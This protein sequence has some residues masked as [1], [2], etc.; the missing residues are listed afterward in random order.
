MNQKG[1]HRLHGE[2]VAP[3]IKSYRF[4]SDTVL[5]AII[6]H[7]IDQPFGAY[8]AALGWSS[9]LFH[10]SRGGCS[11]EIVPGLGLRTNSW[12]N[13]RAERV[14]TLGFLGVHHGCFDLEKN[15]LAC[16]VVCPWYFCQESQTQLIWILESWPSKPWKLVIQALSRPLSPDCCVYKWEGTES[17]VPPL[18]ETRP[19][20]GGFL[21]SF[22][23]KD[24]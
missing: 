7:P 6:S 5:N 18:E 1:A 15:H 14:L 24:K 19:W 12:G 21:R 17:R 8:F 9:T 22:M 11:D 10:P 4:F 23:F 20:Y 16:F 13:G 2:L 3:Q